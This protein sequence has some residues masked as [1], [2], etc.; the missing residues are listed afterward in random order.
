MMQAVN[1]TTTYQTEEITSTGNFLRINL[2]ID[3]PKYSDMAD[4]SDETREY[5]IRQVNSQIINNSVLMGQ[6]DALLG[7]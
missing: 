6:L 7:S 3:E 4:S 1:Q 5:L 2:D